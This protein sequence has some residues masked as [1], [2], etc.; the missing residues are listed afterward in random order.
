MVKL[1]EEVW[2]HDRSGTYNGIVEKIN[3]HTINVI[4]QDSTRKE[5][6][7]LWRVTDFFLTKTP[8]ESVIQWD[9]YRHKLSEVKDMLE[10]RRK[11]HSYRRG[12]EVIVQPYEKESY[13]GVVLNVDRITLILHTSTNKIMRVD[14]AIATP[15]E[16]Y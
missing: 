14:K 13:T 12:S 11:S 16:Y 10:I 1:K 9:A 6:Y 3:K 8:E 5:G 15:T 4:V 2:F 7:Q